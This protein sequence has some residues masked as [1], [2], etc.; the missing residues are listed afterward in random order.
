MRKEGRVWWEAG[1]RVEKAESLEGTLGELV[2]LLEDVG[3]EECDER[4]GSGRKGGK[5]RVEGKE[6]VPF[7]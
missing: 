5:K 3:F 1:L 7:W 4:V 6:Y 2:G